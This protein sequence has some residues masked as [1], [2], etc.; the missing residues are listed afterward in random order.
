MFT[1]VCWTEICD[2]SWVMD[3]E[4]RK[5]LLV[6][7]MC[8]LGKIIVP[9]ISPR[10]QL[11]AGKTWRTWKGRGGSGSHA[12]ML[13]RCRHC[14]PTPHKGW[15]P[16]A[17]LRHLAKPIPEDTPAQGPPNPLHQEHELNHEIYLKCSRLK[18]G[19]A[20]D[21]ADEYVSSSAEAGVFFKCNTCNHVKNS[22]SYFPASINTLN[23]ES[24]TSLHRA[25]TQSQKDII[26][27][28]KIPPHFAI[29]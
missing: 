17:H 15:G 11:W 29:L 4:T 20:H 22:R 2:M 18:H 7:A 27:H 23:F 13:P 16:G 14:L 3:L 26:V 28:G 1:V 25:L 9:E 24:M 19:I 10:N 6:S 21:T 12:D 8:L 5:Y